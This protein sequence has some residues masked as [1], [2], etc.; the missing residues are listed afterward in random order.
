MHDGNIVHEQYKH[1]ETEA[2]RPGSFQTGPS[3]IGTARFSRST[4]K[5]MSCMIPNLT[6]SPGRKEAANF[7]RA[8]EDVHALLTGGNKFTPHDRYLI[9]SNAIELLRKVRLDPSRDPS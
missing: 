6:K 7:L 4:Q 2:R 8:C 5:G 9:E 1:R 3:F